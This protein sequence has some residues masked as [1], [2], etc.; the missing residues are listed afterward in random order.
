MWPWVSTVPKELFALLTRRPTGVGWYGKRRSPIVMEYRRVKDV[1]VVET[2][3]KS[4]RGGDVCKCQDV[5][6]PMAIG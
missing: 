1:L 4:V 2:Q 6:V 3:R 5:H